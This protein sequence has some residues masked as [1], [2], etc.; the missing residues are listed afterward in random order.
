MVLTNNLSF[1]E[2][3]LYA[4]HLDARSHLV[5]LKT[6]WVGEVLSQ[7]WTAKGTEA[8]GA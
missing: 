5:F 7:P 8:Q 1:I 2:Y 6:L 3:L 4:E